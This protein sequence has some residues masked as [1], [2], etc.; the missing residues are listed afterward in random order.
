MET[1]ENAV[2]ISITLPSNVNNTIKIIAGKEQRSIS[3]VIQEA[4]RY[5]IRAKELESLQASL[6]PKAAAVGVF[7][8]DD[9]DEFLH[10]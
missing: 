7:S 9:L 2:K 3:G 5:Y 8:E 4:A 1:S 6:A 10:S